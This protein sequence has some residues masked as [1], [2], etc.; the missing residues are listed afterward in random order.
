M[1]ITHDTFWLTV[2]VQEELDNFQVT[3]KNLKEIK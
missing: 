3:L 2:Y 1:T